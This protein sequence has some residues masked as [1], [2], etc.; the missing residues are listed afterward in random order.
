MLTGIDELPPI[1]GYV[2]TSKKDNPLVE[3]VL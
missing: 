1:K 3:T 2:L